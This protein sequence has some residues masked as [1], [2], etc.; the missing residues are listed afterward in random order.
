MRKFD[1]KTKTLTKRVLRRGPILLVSDQGDITDYE[2]TV[3]RGDKRARRWVRVDTGG[4][5]QLW[6]M[7]AGA[8]GL[9]LDK[10]SVLVRTGTK[11]TRIS[12][13]PVAELHRSMKK[14]EGASF[15]LDSWRGEN[16]LAMKALY[17]TM[18]KD[19]S[20]PILRCL[21]VASDGVRISAKSTD[22][23]R[24]TVA[25][26]ETVSKPIKFEANVTRELIREV[27]FNSAWHLTVWE[28]Y[29]SAEFCDTGVRVQT[30]NVV[31]P[32]GAGFPEI[33]SLM[34]DYDESARGT[35]RVTPSMFAR[36][37]KDLN[38]PRNTPMAFSGKG[39]VASEGSGHFLPAGVINTT[40]EGEAAQWVAMN[41]EYLVQMLQSM[42]GYEEVT[43]TWGQDMKP[44]NFVASDR[45]RSL[46]M[47]VRGAGRSF[48]ASDIFEG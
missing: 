5:R 24:A 26:L 21:N 17:S 33:S 4:S 46:L 40:H 34:Q 20:M 31:S 43:I 8:D 37:V 6:S 44:V 9:S 1:K 36:V 10:D 29:S 22:R 48:P 16:Q 12:G 47:P 23:F 28:D 25:Q 35:W 15:T 41:P 7:I 27:T 13:E 38:P 45:V 19:A 14:P 39:Q 42:A 11:T 2:T 32:S 3:W 30:L 18:G